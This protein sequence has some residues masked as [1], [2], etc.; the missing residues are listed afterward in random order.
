[1]VERIKE[2]TPLREKS[3]REPL[4]FKFEKRNPFQFF[5][6]SKEKASVIFEYSHAPSLSCHVSVLEHETLY[7][8][9]VSVLRGKI[10]TC[11]LR[12]RADDVDEEHIP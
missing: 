8:S 3:H 9:N 11:S 2:V 6:F 5:R 1:M 7:S 10:V 4:Y 12:L